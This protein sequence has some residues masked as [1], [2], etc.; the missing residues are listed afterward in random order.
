MLHPAKNLTSVGQLIDYLHDD[1]PGEAKHVWF[2]GQ[3]FRQWTLVPGIARKRRRRW[4]PEIEAYSINRFKQNASQLVSTQQESSLDWLLTMQHHGV[5]TRLLDWT[6]NPLVG[7]YFAVYQKPRS[8]GTLWIL[9]PARLNTISNISRRFPDIIPSFDDDI[10]QNYSNEALL[11]ERTSHLNPI[12]L[13][14]PRSNP[15]IL[16]QLGVSTISHRDPIAIEN[17]KP[18]DHIWRY[19]IPARSK[20]LIRK[21]L[22]IL[23]INKFTLFPELSSV[24]EM[25]KDEL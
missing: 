10:L 23:G 1:I 7:L 5:P 4:K 14:V 13:I 20:P 25:V 2:R 12:A 8:A 16:T 11:G 17:L 3:S 9:L 21:E 24:G 15:R 19:N 18:G 22:R 6:E